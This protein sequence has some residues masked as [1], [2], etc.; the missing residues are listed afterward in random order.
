MHLMGLLSRRRTLSEDELKLEYPQA[1]SSVIDD[2]A[3]ETGIKGS[4][5]YGMVREES[6]LRP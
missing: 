1:F 4:V 2:L 3:Q 5:L 6:Y